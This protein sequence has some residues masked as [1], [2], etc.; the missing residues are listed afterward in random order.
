M[1]RQRSRRTELLDWWRA[2]LE[3]TR[4]MDGDGFERRRQIENVAWANE[5]AT[6]REMFDPVTA[7]A[8]GMASDGRP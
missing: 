5:L 8:D 3:E 1:A 7:K 4:E 2:V 6:L